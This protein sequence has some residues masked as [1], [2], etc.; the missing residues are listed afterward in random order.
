MEDDLQE[1]SMVV[2]V[3]TWALWL[4]NLHLH[5]QPASQPV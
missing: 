3:E 1:S 2:A 5:T 4:P